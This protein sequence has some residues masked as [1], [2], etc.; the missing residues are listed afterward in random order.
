[1]LVAVG[2]AEAIANNLKYV[3]PPKMLRSSPLYEATTLVENQTFN[4]MQTADPIKMS[5]RAAKL[6]ISSARN[7]QAENDRAVAP[8]VSPGLIDD[9][10]S[11]DSRQETSALD[12][13]YAGITLENWLIFTGGLS[14]GGFLSL[15]GSAFGSFFNP[16]LIQYSR[17]FAASFFFYTYML[18]YEESLFSSDDNLTMMVLYFV[19]FGD[20]LTLG[21]C[22]GKYDTHG[23]NKSLN[24]N[25]A[26]LDYFSI[27]VEAVT[28]SVKVDPI[29]KQIQKFFGTFAQTAAD[30][31]TQ[32]IAIF[33]LVGV[34]TAYAAYENFL[35]FQSQWMVEDY[36][37]AGT[38]LGTAIVE[39]I[40][41][42]V[43]LL[44]TESLL[45]G[46][47]AL[48]VMF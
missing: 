29:V 19:Q 27:D 5:D 32:I 24:A 25:S 28:Q 45:S 40:T 48:A 46:G 38:F 42:L 23:F 41:V 21:Q 9:A 15:S 11:R 12:T 33:G 18:I 16:C 36:F 8:V 4:F 13:E 39:G 31:N 10:Y 43:L 3:I 1:M 30:A 6:P 20:A 14:V 26:L 17:V 2:N 47:Q 22:G 35:T 7:L 34:Q 44:V 37:K